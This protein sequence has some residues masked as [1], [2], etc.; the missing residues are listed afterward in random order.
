MKNLLENDSE[1]LLLC[2]D[3]TGAFVDASRR[4]EITVAL[5]CIRE[6]FAHT[7]DKKIDPFEQ[8]MSLRSL[9]EHF[10]WTPVEIAMVDQLDA[11]TAAMQAS[12][13]IVR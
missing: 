11:Q 5:Q 10:G 4:V 2:D 3:R 7:N 12:A 9:C 8:M 13:G 6:V 1:R